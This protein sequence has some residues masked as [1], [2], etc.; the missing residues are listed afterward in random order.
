ALQL[1]GHGPLPR[2]ILAHVGLQSVHQRR[3]SGGW[4]GAAPSPPR[5][6]GLGADRPRAGADLS[7]ARLQALSLRLPAARTAAGVVGVSDPRAQPRSGGARRRTVDLL[8]V[9]LQ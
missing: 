9:E 2:R 3:I 4:G 7:P 5:R 8:L 6:P 1:H